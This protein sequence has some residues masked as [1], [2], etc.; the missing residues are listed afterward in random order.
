MGG[1]APGGIGG[2]PEFCALGELGGS[3]DPEG[4]FSE[5]SEAIVARV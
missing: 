4:R 1:A 3:C 5:A 2:R